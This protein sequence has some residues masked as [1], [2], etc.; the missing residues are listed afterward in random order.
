MARESA[1]LRSRAIVVL[2]VSLSNDKA[3]S[4]YCVMVRSLLSYLMAFLFFEKALELAMACRLICLSIGVYIPSA[5][6]LF[7]LS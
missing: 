6:V 1:L 5:F 2:I 7:G 4:A 3:S